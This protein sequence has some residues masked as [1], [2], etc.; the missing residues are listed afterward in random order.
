[1]T[2]DERKLAEDGVK[3]AEDFVREIPVV[4]PILADVVG[5][6]SDAIA[7]GHPDPATLVEAARQH[8]RAEL[9]AKLGSDLRARFPR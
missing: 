4:G 5:I 1:M 9:V 7:S 8:I 3:L 6:V 2:P